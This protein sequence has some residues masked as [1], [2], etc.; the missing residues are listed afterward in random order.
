MY[1]YKLDPIDST[2][3]DFDIE[4]NYKDLKFNVGD[5]V[6]ISKKK[7]IFLQNAAL[8][9]KEIF[10]IKASKNTAP[11]RYAMEDL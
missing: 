10:V 1:I 5:Q 8:W 4:N 6:R 7:R 3:I 11:W 9:S 2:P